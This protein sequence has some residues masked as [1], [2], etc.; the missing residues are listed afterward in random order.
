[1]SAFEQ[2][3]TEEKPTRG[4]F[5]ETV[6]LLESL[7]KNL[8]ALFHGEAP[9]KEEYQAAMRADN[10]GALERIIDFFQQLR[11][12]QDLL[13]FYA[14]DY[15]F[16]RLVSSFR[17]FLESYG[18]APPFIATNPKWTLKD[19]PEQ[20]VFECI[21]RYQVVLSGITVLSSEELKEEILRKMTLEDDIAAIYKN[22]LRTFDA[23]AGRKKVVVQYVTVNFKF[24]ENIRSWKR[25]VAEDILLPPFSEIFCGLQKIGGLLMYFI[26]CTIGINNI[27]VLDM[28]LVFESNKEH[29]QYATFDRVKR[30]IV[31]ISIEK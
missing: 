28:I 8:T 3:K 4:I 16:S 6:L 19:F 22:T 15:S 14:A 12:D 25:A 29:T 31:S 5:Y 1:M 11:I 30:C 18:K 23:V 26:K 7:E 2:S 20:E 10:Q 17:A 27:V 21:E 24:T 9:T 13:G